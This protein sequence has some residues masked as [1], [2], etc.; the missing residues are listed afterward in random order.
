MAELDL[1]AWRR[2]ARI[3]LFA[4]LAALKVQLN[5]RISDFGIDGSLYFEVARN[6]RD[7]R[8]LVSFVSLMNAGVEHFPYRTPLYPIWPLLLGYLG[9]LVPMESAA[10][11]LPTI[12]FFAAVLLADRLARQLWPGALFPTVWEV[13]DAGHLAI[14]VLGF[15]PLFFECTSR[16]YTEGLAWFG[17]FVLLA[18]ARS[19]FAAPTTWR[20]FEIG[21]WTGLLILVRAQMFLLTL[22]LAGTLLL[23]VLA[24]APRARWLALAGAAVMGWAAALAPQFA[25]L[26][27]FYDPLGLDA[28]LRF[29]A[30]RASDALAPLQTLRPAPGA[31]SWLADRGQGFTVAYRNGGK[32]AY[33]LNFGVLHWA[34]VFALVLALPRW[35][36]EVARGLRAARDPASAFRVYLSL[37]AVGGFLSLHTLHKDFGSEW[38]FALRHALTV[39]FLF[40]W[41]VVSLGRRPG[42]SSFAAVA[43]VAISA[44]RIGFDQQ[45]LY[46]EVER[47]ASRGTNHWQAL[48]G[49]LARESAA[50]P[51]LVI[52]A[53]DAQRLAA[54]E[55]GL[56][57]HSVWTGTSYADLDGLFGRLDA[58][59]LLL[60]HDPEKFDFA[61]DPRWPETYER[62]VSDL[63]GMDVWQRRA[64]STP[65]LE[66]HHDP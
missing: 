22:V 2:I 24:W 63:S 55:P 43:I 36:S 7:G 48:H 50:N 13:P 52:A 41:G 39:V 26:S 44:W 62:V 66:P 34:P 27:T 59:Y 35:R 15:N 16:P 17:L 19:F 28:V 54:S 12:F 29:D 8:G 14:F 33:M 51:K 45:D 64:P 65:P 38:N 47:E 9:R 20:A 49:W 42:A 37:L 25:W 40:A 3:G 18:R 31:L 58:S 30:F 56:P 5:A 32:Y 46:L 53:T 61:G 21:A 11:W 23:G 10:I 1:A 57:L 6:V 60:D 4:G